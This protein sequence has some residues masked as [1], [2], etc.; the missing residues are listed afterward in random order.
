[1]HFTTVTANLLS[2]RVWCPGC[3]CIPCFKFQAVVLSPLQGSCRETWSDLPCDSGSRL[4]LYKSTVLSVN[5]EMRQVLKCTHARTRLSSGTRWRRG[6]QYGQMQTAVSL[7]STQVQL[8]TCWVQNWVL[9][10]NST[11]NYKHHLHFQLSPFPSA[12]C[13]SW[14][15]QGPRRDSRYL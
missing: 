3:D 8:Q 10:L 15:A 14:L 1:M 6:V 7:R 2:D 13:S 9:S 4:S 5:K 11:N 12:C